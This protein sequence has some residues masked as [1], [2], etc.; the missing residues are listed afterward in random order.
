MS[1]VSKFCATFQYTGSPQSFEFDP[2]VYRFELYGASGGGTLPGYGAYVSG[3]LKLV[4]TRVLHIYVGQ[5]G[6][7]GSNTA[8]NG[9]GK[10]TTYGSSGGGST[11]IRLEGGS[12]DSFSSLKSRIIVA[13]AGG[14][15]QASGY[16]KKA[17][18]AGMFSGKDGQKSSESSTVT[19]AK[20]GLQTSVGV[21][22]TGSNQNGRN[23]EF[24]KGGH[25]SVGDGNGN[26]GGSGYFGGGGSG[27]SPGVVGS[28]AGGSSFVSGLNG[29]KAILRE[30]LENNTQFSDSSVHYSGLK[31]VD[32]SYK[33]GSDSQWNN[34]GMVKISYIR[35]VYF[36]CKRKPDHK[37]SIFFLIIIAS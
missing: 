37:S 4:K 6:V 5:K 15:S 8:W 7:S 28:G 22:G 27:T 17:G 2:G 16:Y 32:I 21:A 35:P 36:S 10:G 24:G 13:G 23:G 14:G 20:G 11:D 29:C 33:E 3:T 1:A 34:N 25:G 12:W 9:G 19:I 26:G 30:S 18:D 31:F